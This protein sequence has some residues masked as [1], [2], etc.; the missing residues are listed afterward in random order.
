VWQQWSE[1]GGEYQKVTSEG[2][3]GPGELQ[4]FYN[5]IRRNGGLL[6]GGIGGDGIELPDYRYL[7]FELKALPLLDRCS[8][9]QVTPLALFYYGYFWDRVLL[10]AQ[11]V[12]D[13]DLLI[14]CFL[15]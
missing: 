10:F 7:G 9:T 1:Y 12:L 5:S 2:D 13:H 4:D 14:L 8:T 15:R 3:G 11:A 6:C